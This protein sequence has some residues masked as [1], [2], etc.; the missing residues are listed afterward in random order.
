MPGGASWSQWVG[1]DE[2]SV[3]GEV[4]GVTVANPASQTS[5]VTTTAGTRRSLSASDVDKHRHA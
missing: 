1:G 3:G 2:R 5:Q 4:G